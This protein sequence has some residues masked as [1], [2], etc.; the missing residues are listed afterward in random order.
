MG[1]MLAQ[2]L[3]SQGRVLVSPTNDELRRRSIEMRAAG[4]LTCTFC[5]KPIT[6]D[7]FAT[8]RLRVGPRHEWVAN[9]HPDCE[10]G[11]IAAAEQRLDPTNV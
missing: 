3:V 10:A 8:R 5:R 11:F 2:A 7:Q 6:D 4:R 1:R 9:L